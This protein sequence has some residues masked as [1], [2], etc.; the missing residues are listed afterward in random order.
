[1][2]N[3]FSALDGSAQVKA[4]LGGAK[5][6]FIARSRDTQ[7]HGGHWEG[8]LDISRSHSPQGKESFCFLGPATYPNAWNSAGGQELV[9]V[10][11][12]HTQKLG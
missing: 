8:E 4:S 6:G 7:I 10:R 12:T 3:V 1:M 11:G 9:T 2:Q 5:S